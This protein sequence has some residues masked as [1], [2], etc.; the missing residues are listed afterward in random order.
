MSKRMGASCPKYCLDG[1]Q[2]DP[3]TEETQAPIDTNLRNAG[4]WPTVRQVWPLVP[5]VALLESKHA[6]VRRQVRRLYST[7]TAQ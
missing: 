1:G 7:T 6:I 5:P 2:I 3:T 4:R